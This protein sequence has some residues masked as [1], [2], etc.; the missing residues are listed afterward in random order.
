MKE[1]F[2]IWCNFT[3]SEAPCAKGKYPSIRS[4]CIAPVLYECFLQLRD[5]IRAGDNAV[6][7]ASCRPD[8]IF[9]MQE[10]LHLGESA[11]H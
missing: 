8:C 2:P 10:F 3:M 4:R 1:L 5:N 11:G 9:M 7:G 6:L